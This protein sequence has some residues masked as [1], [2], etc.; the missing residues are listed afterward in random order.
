MGRTLESRSHVPILSIIVRT[1]WS[2]VRTTPETDEASA[3]EMHV[4][5]HGALGGPQSQGFLL[6][7]RGFSP[8]S[9]PIVGAERLHRVLRDWRADSAGVLFDQGVRVR[10]GDA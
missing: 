4:A 6:Y 9:G 3:F 10:S 7:P 2:T 8:P 1:S 5:S